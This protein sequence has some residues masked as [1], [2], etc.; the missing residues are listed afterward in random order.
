MTMMIDDGAALM[1]LRGSSRD[2]Y[3]LISTDMFTNGVTL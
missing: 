2:H 1:S 3:V